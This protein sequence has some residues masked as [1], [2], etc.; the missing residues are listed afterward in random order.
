MGLIT[1]YE[2]LPKLTPAGVVHH[3]HKV[4]LLAVHFQ[5][6]KV[7]RLAVHHKVP[8]LVVH[9]QAQLLEKK[10]TLTQERGSFHPQLFL[11]FL[12]S[13]RGR[14][15]HMQAKSLLKLTH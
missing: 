10:G 11:S 7:L 6:Q 1:L 15:L 4:Q 2:T 5:L 9:H 13:N 3:H 14:H 8:T 12:K